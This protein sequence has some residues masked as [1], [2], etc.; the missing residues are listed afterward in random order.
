MLLTLHIAVVAEFN[1]SPPALSNV[2][3]YQLVL[4]NTVL[5]AHFDCNTA[6]AKD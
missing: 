3:I 6:T 2:N 1:F 5:S 4:P